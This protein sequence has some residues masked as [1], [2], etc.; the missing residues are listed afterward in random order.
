[1]ARLAL[2]LASVAGS[3]V[4]FAPSALV[5]QALLSDPFLDAYCFRLANDAPEPGLVGLAFEPVRRRD[6]ADIT[7]TLWLDAADARLRYLEFAY[8][9][10]P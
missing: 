8:T 2:L 9:W 10:A 7:G 4:G 3:L 1:M 6:V 5:A